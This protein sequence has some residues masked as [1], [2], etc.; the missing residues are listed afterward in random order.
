MNMSRLMPLAVVVATVA[1]ASN[2]ATS[3]GAPGSSSGSSVNDAGTSGSDT[4]PG[5]DTSKDAGS[6]DASAPPADACTGADCPYDDFVI[7]NADVIDAI[8]TDGTWVY[9]TVE[10][11]NTTPLKNGRVYRMPVAGGTPEVIVHEAEYFHGPIFAAGGQLFFSRESSIK[12]GCCRIVRVGAG[13]GTP[14]LFSDQKIGGVGLGRGM[15]VDGTDVYWLDADEV[16]RAPFAGG[17]GTTIAKYTFPGGDLAVDATHVYWTDKAGV[18]RAPKAGGTATPLRTGDFSE[19][20]ILVAAGKVFVSEVPVAPKSAFDTLAIPVA[21]GAS[22]TIAN[23]QPR[24]F[25][26]DGA[27]LYWVPLEKFGSAPRRVPLSGGQWQLFTAND[28]SE[29]YFGAMVVTDDYV[30]ATGRK[31]GPPGQGDLG[32]VRRY[33]KK[34]S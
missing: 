6:G 13:G 27:F 17:P 22:I 10:D 5:S 31:F 1:C 20:P 11:P 26:A 2:D 21:G 29:Q 18:F 3:S 24:S 33:K 34:K 19:S 16:K 8:T 23:D 4:R 25:G 14:E 32:V 12:N 7:P 30:F 9:A 15:A 28:F